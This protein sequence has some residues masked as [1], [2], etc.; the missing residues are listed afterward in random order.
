MTKLGDYDFHNLFIAGFYT[1][2]LIMPFWY[3]DKGKGVSEYMLEGLVVDP[4][5]GRLAGPFISLTHEY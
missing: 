3:T 1:G 5:P 4:V 2:W